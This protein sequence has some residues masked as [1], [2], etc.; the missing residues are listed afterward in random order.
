VKLNEEIYGFVVKDNSRYVTL[1]IIG[2]SN[3]SNI[4]GRCTF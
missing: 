1:Y 2:K 4:L 3:H